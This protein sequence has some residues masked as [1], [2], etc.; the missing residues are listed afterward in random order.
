MEKELSDQI[1]AVKN[2]QEN[3]K[4]LESII[5]NKDTKINELTTEL[6]A[7]KKKVESLD[8]DIVSN[9]RSSITEGNTAADIKKIKIL[10]DELK[11]AS[12][13]LKVIKE[14]NE[15]YILFNIKKI[16]H[17]KSLKEKDSNDQIKFMRNSLATYR[18]KNL[19]ALKKIQDRSDMAGRT[20]IFGFLSVMV[21]FPYFDCF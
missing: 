8:G 14:E 9:L 12:N 6:L 18:K 15:V 1:N 13:Q 5:I 16:L 2:D 19:D 10:E 3:L 7:L 20:T 17:E 11:N 4:K 21:R